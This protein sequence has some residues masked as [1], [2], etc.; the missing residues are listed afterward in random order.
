MHC[1]FNSCELTPSLH[2]SACMYADACHH[3][4]RWL[5]LSG[6]KHSSGLKKIQ[7]TE[8]GARSLDLEQLC[9]LIE[10]TVKSIDWLGLPRTSNTN[11][12]NWNCRRKAIPT[13]SC[14]HVIRVK[15]Q[16]SWQGERIGRIC[17]SF[18]FN[19]SN[20]SIKPLFSWRYRGRQRR[21]HHRW[22]CDAS[23]WQPT[24]T[25]ELALGS[26]GSCRNLNASDCS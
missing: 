20:T 19:P 15:C 23:C 6:A 11:H 16:I 9:N 2:G 17:S 25:E 26:S 13:I 8:K 12:Y 18:F 14:I 10:A 7:C 24:A 1:P 5:L 4:V 21:F 3:T 22:G